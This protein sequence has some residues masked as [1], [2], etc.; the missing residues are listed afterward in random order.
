MAVHMDY[1]LSMKQMLSS[2]IHIELSDHAHVMTNTSSLMKK[3]MAARSSGV[4]KAVVSVT[5]MRKH[6]NALNGVHTDS[7]STTK[8]KSRSMASINQL[9]H[10]D[11]MTNPSILMKKD[12]PVSTSSVLKLVQKVALREQIDAG[13]RV[14]TD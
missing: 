9:E 8:E 11:V 2:R 7:D 1:T 12:I 5:A 4:M 6:R 10:V 13:T 3:R 14:I